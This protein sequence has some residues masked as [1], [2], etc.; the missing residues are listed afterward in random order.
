MSTWAQRVVRALDETSD[1]TFCTGLIFVWILSS[2]LVV[3]ALLS[4]S[5]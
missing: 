5:H 3:T 2:G 4:L 1:R